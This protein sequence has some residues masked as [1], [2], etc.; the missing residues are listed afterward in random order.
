M[1]RCGVAGFGA[2][3]GVEMTLDLAA[4]EQ[5][6]AQGEFFL[7]YLP[8]IALDDGRCVG[9]EAL[10]RWARAGAIVQP[11]E[12]IPVV[13]NTPV[14]GRLTHWVMDTIA[15]ELS[16]WLRAHPGVHVGINVPPELLGRGGI[17]YAAERSGLAEFAR[18][19]VLEVTE[20]GVPDALGIKGLDAAHAVGVR[21][22][23]DDVSLTGPNLAILARV[24]FHIV[25]VDRAQVRQIEPSKPRPGWLHGLAALLATTKLDV[26]AEGVETEF[27][28]SVLRECG[29]RH[30][31]GFYFAQPMSARELE[32]FHLRRRPLEVP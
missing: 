5:G 13:E 8:T 27:Q 25:K 16:H 12:F 4:I 31:Q 28:V 10:I 30:A 17:T 9:A 26:V 7:E 22:A 24:P 11:D 3:A 14:S 23:L 15:A 18:Q 19:I 32:A 29:I 2:R 20:R 1:A 6:L 21:V